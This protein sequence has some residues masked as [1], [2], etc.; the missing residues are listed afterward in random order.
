MEMQRSDEIP[1]VSANLIDRLP[2]WISLR[3]NQLQKGDIMKLLP[4]TLMVTGAAFAL[5]GCAALGVLTQAQDF[6]DVKDQVDNLTTTT[7]MPTSGSGV[8]D[9]NAVIGADY[10]ANDNVVLLGDAELTATFTNTG[11]TLVGTLDNFSGLVLTDTQ[12]TQVENGNVPDDIIRAAKN[13]SGTVAISSGTIA[14][15]AVAANSSGTIRMDGSDYVVSGD[16]IGEFRGTNAAAVQMTEGATFNMTR[17]GA[18]PTTGSTIEVDA[19]K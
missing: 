3:A 9:G 15:S 17:D 13:A 8:Y 5:S 10:G 2:L 11:G 4:T 1:T 18:N 12:R 6:A 16:L 19:V 7:T 14:G